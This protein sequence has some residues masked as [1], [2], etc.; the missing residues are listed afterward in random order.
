MRTLRTIPPRLGTALAICAASACQT[1]R[2]V[3]PAQ[4]SRSTIS[5]VWITK[6][7]D[8]TIVLMHPEVHGDTLAGFVDGEYEEMRL[9]DARSLRARRPAPARTALVTVAGTAAAIGALVYFENRPYVG[10]GEACSQAV[11]Q[12]QQIQLHCTGYGDAW[13]R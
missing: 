12:Q 11:Q 7:N 9:S 1:M 5:R 8:S 10:G 3:Q 2:T 13:T 6:G 4:L